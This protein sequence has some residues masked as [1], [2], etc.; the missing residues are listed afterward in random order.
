LRLIVG[1][2][3]TPLPI[4]SSATLRDME[5]RLE[6]ESRAEIASLRSW[7]ADALDAPELDDDAGG[8]WFR[9]E[10][11]RRAPGRGAHLS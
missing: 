7:F 9:A 6:G 5:R 2:A 11:G 1:L 4:A 8:F 10:L 3:H